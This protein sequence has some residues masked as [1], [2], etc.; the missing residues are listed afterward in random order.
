M[1]VHS[2]LI[3]LFNC[4]CRFP[5]H[6]SSIHQSSHCTSS[7]Y[8][9]SLPFQVQVIPGFYNMV[10]VS[11]ACGGH[12]ISFLEFLTQNDTRAHSWSSYVSVLRHFFQL[13]EIDNHSLS[14]RKITLFIKSVSFNSSYFPKYKATFTIPILTKLVHAC[15]TIRYGFIFKAIFLLAY[16]AF[17]RLSNMAPSSSKLFDSTRH[18]L[19][20]DV[21]FGPSGAHIIVKWTKAMQGASKHQIVQI[22]ALP[23]SPSV[24]FQPSNSFPP[25]EKKVLL[26]LDLEL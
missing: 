23:S 24:P 1:K 21:V 19:R 8:L 9:S 22:P 7:P 16:F 2:I 13:Y 4:R 14:H 26:E 20:A 17:L 18:F 10:S 15:H 3:I 5:P 12:Y 6:P 11:P 25:F